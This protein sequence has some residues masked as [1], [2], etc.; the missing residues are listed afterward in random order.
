MKI[1]K[2]KIGDVFEIRTARGLVY[3]QFSY[4]VVEDKLPIVRVLPGY[5]DHRPGNL[6]SLVAAQETFLAFYALPYAAKDGSAVFLDNYPLPPHA[7]KVPI[8]RHGGPEGWYIGEVTI[9][10]TPEGY[11][12]F[13]KVKSL[14]DQERKLSLRD[15]I[16]PHV[17]LVKALER[18]WT[19]EK[20]EE[21]MRADGDANKQKTHD[22]SRVESKSEYLDH[23]F[24]FD[25]S[26]KAQR[27]ASTMR[28]KGWHAEVRRSKDG[29]NWLVVAKQPVAQIGEDEVASL[30]DEFEA[31]AAKFGGE[32]DGWGI[33]TSGR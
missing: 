24:Y 22:T 3:L 32:Y 8:K 30:R 10:M 19:P 6:Q 21:M 7:Q 4:L 23:Y 14:S 27:L 33:A 15:T 17:A 29:E 13:K 11:K 28:D 2:P 18:G 31:L 9:P 20:D 5:H 16:Y 12:R 1:R 25:E 26:V